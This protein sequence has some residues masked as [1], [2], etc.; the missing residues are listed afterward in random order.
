MS[1]ELTT[2]EPPGETIAGVAQGRG[3][4][5]KKKK[6]RGDKLRSAWISFVGR[7]VA[8]LVGAVATVVLGVLML[9]KYS[10]AQTRTDNSASV[11]R[12]V[13]SSVARPSV[14][15]RI[16]AQLVDGETDQPVWAHT[17]DRPLDDFLPLQ[18]E[19]ATAIAQQVNATLA[20]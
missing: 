4:K 1:E 3:Q 10:A 9:Q 16:I 17:Y 13:E 6:R 20:P 11:Q 12:V 7:I 5:D 18:A 15:V 2:S 8:Q 14:R 19:V